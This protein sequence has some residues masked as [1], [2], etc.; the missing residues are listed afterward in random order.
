MKKI[1]C[2]VLFIVVLISFYQFLY[3][4]FPFLPR[5]LPETLLLKNSGAL[6]ALKCWQNGP[7]NYCFM[8]KNAIVITPGFWRKIDSKNIRI[9]P[10]I[11]NADTFDLEKATIRYLYVNNKL[12]RKFFPKKNENDFTD[13]DN[14]TYVDEIAGIIF[15]FYN[16][17]KNTHGIALIDYQGNNLIVLYK[18][19]FFLKGSLKENLVF[20]KDFLIVITEKE[21][22]IKI[23]IP[24]NYIK[25][26]DYYNKKDLTLLNEIIKKHN[27][28]I[29][30]K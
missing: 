3:L 20:E 6:I 7:I 11:Y 13:I 9:L 2:I 17:F 29:I 28:I 27:I 18:G 26:K 14:I 22:P 19:E 16:Y 23:R 24:I 4:A 21:K 1:I 30:K 25:D 10:G 12:C 8:A 15:E 5:I